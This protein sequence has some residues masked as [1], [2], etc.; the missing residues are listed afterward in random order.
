MHTWRQSRCGNKGFD[1]GVRTGRWPL[2]HV[3][4]LRGCGEVGIRIRRKHQIRCRAS[5]SGKR[6]GKGREREESAIDDRGGR[7]HASSER[8]FD[9]KTGRGLDRAWRRVGGVR[10]QNQKQ[11]SVWRKVMTDRDW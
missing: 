2:T 4:A 5:L 1:T 3:A 8:A 7:G 10:E 6:K 11:G 9:L